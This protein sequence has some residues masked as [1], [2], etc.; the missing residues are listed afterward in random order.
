MCRSL[1]VSLAA[2]PCLMLA[3]CQTEP[4]H[5]SPE[6]AS[7]AVPASPAAPIRGIAFA[8]HLT[9]QS[10]WSVHQCTSDG[11]ANACN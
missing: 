5:P 8:P 9:G 7:T 6:T 2:A 4:V 1:I 10:H 11:T 3:A